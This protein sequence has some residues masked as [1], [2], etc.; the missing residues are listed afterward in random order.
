[1]PNNCTHKKYLAQVGKDLMSVPTLWEKTL[2]PSQF[3]GTVACLYPFCWS[4][5]NVKGL[6]KKY[7]FLVCVRMSL[8][9]WPPNHTVYWKMKVV[10]SHLCAVKKVCNLAGSCLLLKVSTQYEVSLLFSVLVGNIFSM[11]CILNA[12]EN[13]SGSFLNSDLC[14]SKTLMTRRIFCIFY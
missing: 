13:K 10:V 6:E 12:Y 8:T 5:K 2:P 1:M 3:L 9:V 7:I 4:L 14:D 11:W